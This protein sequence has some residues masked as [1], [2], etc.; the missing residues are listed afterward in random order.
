MAAGNDIQR[1]AS[2]LERPRTGYVKRLERAQRAL[3]GRSGTASG[4]LGVFIDRI[5]DL[6]IEELCELYDETFRADE[7]TIGPLVERLV[8][9]WV[10]SVEAGA[11]L[12]TLSPLLDRLESERNP[13]ACAVRSLSDLLLLEV[14]RSHVHERSNSSRAD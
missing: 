12:T 9:G 2:A 1:V 7:A 4:Q 13:Y 6:T 5:A 3:A 8:H 14:T 10:G 11:A